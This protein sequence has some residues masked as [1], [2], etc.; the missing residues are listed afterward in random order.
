MI[1]SCMQIIATF[2]PETGWYIY[3]FREEGSPANMGIHCEDV[4]DGLHFLLMQI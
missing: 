4:S 1:Y 2:C 3:I